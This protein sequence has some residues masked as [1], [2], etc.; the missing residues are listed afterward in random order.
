MIRNPSSSVIKYVMVPSATI[1]GSEVPRLRI[2]ASSAVCSGVSGV[3]VDWRAWLKAFVT[4]AG[5]CPW[6]PKIGSTSNL[7]NFSTSPPF[8]VTVRICLASRFWVCSFATVSGAPTTTAPVLNG[9]GCR[10]RHMIVVPVT[11]QDDIR[12]LHVSRLEP[13]RSE[14]AAAIEVGVQKHDLAAVG[15][16][17]IGVASPA[18]RQR[19]RVPW[20]GAA[21]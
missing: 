17:E 6:R 3:A 14:H 4:L 15:Q 20:S 2:T 7:P 16:L 9:D 21:G 18:D 11:D 1:R 8:P 5:G 19:V 10:I 12:L 13:Q